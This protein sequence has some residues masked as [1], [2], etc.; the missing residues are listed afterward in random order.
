MPLPAS[1]MVMKLSLLFAVQPQLLVDN[2]FTLP[3][4]PAA[5]K[6]CVKGE[7][8]EVTDVNDKVVIG[9]SLGGAGPEVE[10]GTGAVLLSWP[11]VAAWKLSFV[12]KVMEAVPPAPR[13]GRKIERLFVTPPH[14]VP[15][16]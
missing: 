1:V 9:V 16:G 5:S 15:L 11:R 12:K 4:P 3:K 13:E 10:D 6:A 14:P 2:T 8:V 7:I